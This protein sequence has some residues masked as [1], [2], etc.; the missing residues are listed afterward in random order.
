MLPHLHAYILQTATSGLGEG[1]RVG[2]VVIRHC[3]VPQRGGG[4]RVCLLGSCDI[5]L[6]IYLCQFREKL[7]T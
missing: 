4:P 1:G 7:T 2:G 3:F 6:V 5:G